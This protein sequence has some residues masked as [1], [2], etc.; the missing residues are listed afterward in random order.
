MKPILIVGQG[1]AGT[2]LALSL[3]ERKIPFQILNQK[4]EN[5]ASRIASGLYNPIVLK[6]MKA[7]WEGDYFIS[8]LNDFY[9]K[10]EALLEKKFF[11]QSNIIRLFSTIQEQNDWALHLDKPVLKNHLYHETLRNFSSTINSPFGLGIV[12]GC[13]WVDT[14]IFLD[15]AAS[16]FQ[17]LEVLTEQKFEDYSDLLSDEFLSSFKHIIFCE[18]YQITKNPFFENLPFAFT[19]GE[20][21]E[22]YSNELKL[23]EIIN[24]G[25]FIIPLGDNLYKVGATYSWDPI[26]EIPTTQELQNLQSSLDKIITVPYQVT[27]HVAGIRPTVKDRKPIIGLHH[28]NKK[29]GIFNGLGS[30]GILMAPGLAA[31][32]IDHFID[33]QPLLKGCELSR[34]T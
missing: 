22:I 24:A 7:V 13:G 32:F 14:N 19:K 1:I 25:I 26:N 11:F 23:N 4:K 29:I 12:T 5:S 27:K 10:A 15:A 30:R 28:Q 20:V 18:G 6:R 16:F 2:I 3:Y 21:M 17:N 31:N 9:P 34:F 33:D 8:K